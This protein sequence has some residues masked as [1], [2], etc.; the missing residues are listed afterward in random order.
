M[1]DRFGTQASTTSAGRLIGKRALVTGGGS[2]IGRAVALRYA[3]EGARVAVVGR[4]SDALEDTVALARSA[5]GEAQALPCDVTQETDV[6]RAVGSVVDS[7]GGLDVLV[8]VAGVEP[9]GAGD[10]RIHEVSLQVW[11]QVLDINLTGMFLAC[12]YGIAAM[13]RSGGGSVIV[14]GSPCGLTGL[15]GDEAAYSASK[16]GTHGLVRAMAHAYAADHIRA[17]G[18]IPG[19]IDTP[20]NAAVMRDT[21]ALRSLIDAIPMRRPG[22]PE[23]VAPLYVWLASDEASYVTGAFFTADGGMTAV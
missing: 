2:G 21:E 22:Q 20:L 12:R 4:R 3:Q 19:F 9:G 1:S 23:E 5:G 14:T 11:Q 13:L 7:W 6:A 8:G 10:G 16:A 18:V 15:C 17:N